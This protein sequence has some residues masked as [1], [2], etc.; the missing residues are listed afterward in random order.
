MY[1]YVLFKALYS[2]LCLCIVSRFWIMFS[3]L[4]YAQFNFSYVQHIMC[5]TVHSHLYLSSPKYLQ[6]IVNS[7][8][9]AVQ[10]HKV[11]IIAS[12]L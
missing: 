5:T 7:T 3:P 12:G 10:V 4:P 9:A 11:L 6:Y 8:N 2:C 1:P